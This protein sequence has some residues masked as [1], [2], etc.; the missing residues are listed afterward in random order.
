M[1]TITFDIN[2][3]GWSP[4]EE[5]VYQYLKCGTSYINEILEYCGYIY[6]SRIYAILGAKWDTKLKNIC[7]ICDFGPLQFEIIKGLGDVWF[8]EITQ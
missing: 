7:Y 5:V 6:L 4:N 8:I 2:C 3:I 1:S